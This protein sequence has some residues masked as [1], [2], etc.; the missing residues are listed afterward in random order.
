MNDERSSMPRRTILATVV[1]LTLL[2]LGISGYFAVVRERR[3]T[4]VKRV[5]SAPD[6]VEA[7]RITNETAPDF[8]A[9][10]DGLR[11][12][13]YPIRYSAPIRTKSAEALRSFLADARNYPYPKDPRERHTCVPQPGVAIRFWRDDEKVDAI[14]CFRCCEVWLRPTGGGYFCAH[15]ENLKTVMR[16]IFPR[17]AAFDVPYDPA[18]PE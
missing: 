4:L 5:L 3:L 11:I 18:V 1:V 14:F 16:T 15:R 10:A 17:E 12:E 7:F 6:R 9:Y 8:K 13:R 2:A